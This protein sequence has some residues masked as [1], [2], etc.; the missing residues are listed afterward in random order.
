MKKSISVLVLSALVLTSCGSMRESRLNP[1]NWFGRS[2]AQP[3]VTEG[4]VNPLIPRR[5]VSIFRDNQPE[6]YNGSLVGE[7]TELLI[8]R[9]PGGAIIRATAITDRQGPFELRLVKVDAESD[10]DTLTYDFRA[11]QI[12]GPRGSDLSRTYTAALWLTDQDLFGIRE[13]RVK[14]RRTVRTSRR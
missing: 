2:T 14:S 8:E 10:A 3:V 4:E 9:R 13:I 12:P 11:L 7:V 6:A 1:F 5:R